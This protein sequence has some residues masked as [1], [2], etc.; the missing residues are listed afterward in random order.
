MMKHL[1][2]AVSE[3]LMELTS[4]RTGLQQNYLLLCDI[5]QVTLFWDPR[6][7]PQIISR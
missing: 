6:N 2:T 5:F 4:V 3:E 1:V 7:V